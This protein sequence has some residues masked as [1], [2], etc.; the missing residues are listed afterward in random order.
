MDRK[1][2]SLL[3]LRLV[4]RDDETE[5]FEGVDQ[6]VQAVGDLDGSGG[7]AACGLGVGAGSVPAYNR[8]AGMRSEQSLTGAEERP[9]SSARTQRRSKS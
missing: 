1:P 6:K 2:G 8:Y 9:G 3:D 5:D 7:A 4:T